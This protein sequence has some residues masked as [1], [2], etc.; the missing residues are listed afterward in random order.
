VSG[1][2]PSF[3]LHVDL[4]HQSFHL[5]QLSSLEGAVITIKSDQKVAK[6]CYENSLKTKRG[7]CTITN[8]P[9][10]GEGVA[11]AKMARERR[12]EPAREVMKTK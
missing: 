4:I 6:K 7:V 2:L 11:R 9:Q 5:Q 3:R 1:P 10:R 8:Q 12:P